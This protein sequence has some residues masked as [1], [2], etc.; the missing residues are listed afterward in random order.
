MNSL[1]AY[2]GDFS[3]P[4]PFGNNAQAVRRFGSLAVLAALLVAFFY[5]G[6]TVTTDNTNVGTTNGLWKS[7]SVYLWEHGGKANLDS[8]GFFYFPVYGYLSRLIPDG[9]VQY[10]V[11]APVVT[12]RKMAILNGLFGG[13]AS[14]LVFFLALRWSNSPVAACLVTLIHA[15]AGFV[16]LNSVNSEDIVPAYTFFLGASVCFFEFLFLKRIWLLIAAALLL[17][18]ATLFH[19]TTT[20]PALAAFGSVLALLIFKKRTGLLLGAAW[21][22]LYVC[23]LQFAVLFAFRPAVHIPIWQVLYPA[24]GANAGGWVGL[25]PEKFLFLIMG[26]GNYFT[27]AS[28]SASYTTGLSGNSLKYVI[29]SWLLFLPALGAIVGAL[30]SKRVNPAMKYLAVF[31]FAL[32]AAGE[33]GAFYS[34]PQDPQMQIQPMFA[35]IIGIILLACWWDP[36][37]LRA[38]TFAGLGVFAIALSNGALNVCLLRAG[39]GGDSRALKEVN[40]LEVLFPPSNTIIV[41]QGFESWTTWEFVVTFKG[42]SDD[43]LAHSIQLASA[44]TGDRG[45]SGEAAAVKTEKQIDAAMARGFHVVANRLWNEPPGAL[46]DSITTVASTKDARVYEEVLRANYRP[47]Q[48]WTTGEGTFVE[49]LPKK[50]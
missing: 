23:I 10:G 36:W 1:L 16:L 29:V 8:G 30:L 17:A 44:F 27:G 12:F 5:V 47:G 15:G 50:P 7:P 42:A 37:P 3:I 26:M 4:L 43:F 24:K 25:R 22:G 39:A 45:I 49:L 32:L 28:N 2:L 13:M 19:W 38:R 41:C 9:W 33:F 31:A 21:F 34:Q 18:L 35:A 20:V 46:A 48:S 40:Q 11:A 6:F 14:G